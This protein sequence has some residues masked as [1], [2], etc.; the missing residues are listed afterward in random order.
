LLFRNAAF[1]PLWAS[2]LE[3]T[4]MD[5]DEKRNSRR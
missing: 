5:C 1:I 2:A 3:M 4:S